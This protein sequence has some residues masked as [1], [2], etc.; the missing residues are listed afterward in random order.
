MFFISF[1]FHSFVMASCE[2]ATDGYDDIVKPMD[3]LLLMM[4]YQ[5]VHLPFFIEQSC[6]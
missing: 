6:L 4:N 5:Q 2:D 1:F 3:R